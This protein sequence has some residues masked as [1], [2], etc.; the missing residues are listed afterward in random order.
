[1]L[2]PSLK[3]IRLAIALAGVALALAAQSGDRTVYRGKTGTKY[4]LES[5]HT[6]RGK[7]IPIRLSEAKR[8]GREPCKVCKPGN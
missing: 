6:L 2:R 8:E 4:H 5:C 7:G 1:M 3:R